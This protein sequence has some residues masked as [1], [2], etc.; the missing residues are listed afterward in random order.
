MAGCTVLEDRSSCQSWLTVDLL[1]VDKGIKEWHLWLFNDQGGLLFKDTIHRRHYT[2]PYVVEVPRHGKVQ[3]FMWGNMRDATTL[4]EAYS[5]GTFILK[6]GGVS[7]DSLYSCTDTISTS[8]EESYLKVV[9]DK[10]FATVDIYMKGWVGVDFEV[11]MA[12]ECA[13]SGFFVDKRLCGNRNITNLEISDIGNYY[14]CFTGRILRQYDTENLILTLYVK[15]L[16]PDGTQ[17]R[18]LYDMD[19]PIGDY[20]EGNGY[21]MYSGGMEDITMEL[22]FSYN[23]LLIRAEDWSAEY[24][25]VEEI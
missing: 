6:E 9:P 7:A 3:C 19:I 4:N 13:S 12:I 21:N 17:G 15:E 2:A 22:D 8:G 24:K 14:T 20:L 25:I 18:V 5:L 11:E 16:L 10:E 23:N 1:G